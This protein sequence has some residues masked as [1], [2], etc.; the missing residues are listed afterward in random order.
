MAKI[1]L[2]KYDNDKDGYIDGVWRIYSA[3]NY[4]NNGPVTDDHNYW[5]YTYWGNQD[6]KGNVKADS[7]KRDYENVP[8]KED[9][10]E[11]FKREVLPYN[12][13]AWIDKKKTQI[14]KTFKV[15]FTLLIIIVIVANNRKSL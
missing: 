4:E 2:T 3:H 8:L 5:A 6:K 7:N 15:Y 14:K 12:N 10:E 1:D 13:N 9:I 11:Y